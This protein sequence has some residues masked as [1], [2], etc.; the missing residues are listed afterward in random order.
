MARRRPGRHA[1]RDRGLTPRRWLPFVAL[2]AVVAAAVVVSRQVDDATTEEVVVSSPEA[3]LPVAGVV[4]PISSTWFCGGGTA[5]GAG[6]RADLSVVVANAGD[7][8]AEALF[9]FYGADGEPTTETVEV[10]ANDRVRVR[11]REVQEGEWA[12]ATV[13]VFGG[14]PTV[15]RRIDGEH[16]FEQAPCASSASDTWYVPSGSTLRGA[17]ETLFLFNP[18]PDATSVDVAFATDEGRIAPQDLTGVAIPARSLRVVT[19]ENPA[20]RREVAAMVTTRTGRIVVDRL[21]TYDGT[22]DPVAGE[23]PEA[24]ETEAPRGLASTAAVATPAERWFF[25]DVRMVAG[26]RTQLAVLNPSEETADLEVVVGF[27]DPTLYEEVPPIQLSVRAGEQALYDLADDADFL[28]GMELTL[29]VRSTDGVPVVAELVWLTGE[30]D[31]QE[32]PT[33]DDP[34]AVVNPDGGETDPDGGSDGGSEPDPDAGSDAD[35]ATDPEAEDDPDGETDPEEEH[36]HA[37][38]DELVVE[39][40]TVYAPGVAV[41]AGS[42]VAARSWFLAGRGA[43]AAI[44]SEIVVANPS[45]SPVEVTVVELVGGSQRDVTSATVTVPAGGRATV[46]LTDAQP[47]SP[48]ILSGDGP[49]VV[50]RTMWATTG[51]GT[52]IDLA[53]PFPDQVVS[54]PTR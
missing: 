45:A 48:L 51:R 3:L 29:D 26:S 32:G 36:D 44:T 11:A 2:I 1:R 31:A 24:I 15:E 14:R 22:G 21:Q 10:P 19:I 41:S 34:D 40:L 30:R 42:P 12:A 53:T 54:L 47:G 37:H 50:A 39:E 17:T 8:G 46:D 16:G 49:L 13:E 5:T 20:R 38:D 35:P 27:D 28:P 6:E 7:T 4:D 23:G 52:S 18:F 43:D 25:P 33:E 9:T